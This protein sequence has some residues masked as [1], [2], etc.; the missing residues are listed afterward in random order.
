MTPFI[1]HLVLA[2]QHFFAG[3]NQRH[4]HLHIKRSK[5]GKTWIRGGWCAV[6]DN[7]FECFSQ[8]NFW[9]A[10]LNLLD[11]EIFSESSSS[12]AF[13]KPIKVTKEKQGWK[14][15]I[16]LKCGGDHKLGKRV[17]EIHILQVP[18]QACEVEEMEEKFF[19]QFCDIEDV[20][21]EVF[22]WVNWR[23]G[24]LQWRD[25]FVKWC[26]WTFVCMK[27]LMKFMLETLK[28]WNCLWVD[29]EKTKL[30]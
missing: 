13:Q 1:T 26:G 27:M 23:D 22:V 10:Y 4:L 16:V 24:R 2:S 17:I 30:Y 19:I 11:D 21:N 25:K 29:Y 14:I 18:T 6:V 20:I 15:R 8:L 28:F 5:K 9:T 12:R 7:Y 3:V